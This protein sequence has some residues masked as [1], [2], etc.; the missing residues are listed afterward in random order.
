MIRSV[1]PFVDLTLSFGHCLPLYPTLVQTSFGSWSHGFCS[2]DFTFLVLFD[3]LGLSSRQFGSVISNL[4]LSKA[5]SRR[6][7]SAGV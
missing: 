7:C 1:S 5:I 4:D 6:I 3:A 2:K